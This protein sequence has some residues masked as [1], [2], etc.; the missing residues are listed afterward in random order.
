MTSIGEVVARLLQAIE[1]IDRAAIN[2]DGARNESELSHKSFVE[3]GQG[4][5]DPRMR[6]A[7]TESRTAS[8]KAGK[9]ARLL[10]EAAGHF[11]AYINIIAP[12]SA[13]SP[14]DAMPSG[15]EL[16]AEAAARER[17]ASRYHRKASEA[18]AN[19]AEKIQKAEQATTELVSIIKDRIR[20]GDAQANVATPAKPPLTPPQAPRSGHP[21]AD[22]VLAA[23]AV[24][25]AVRAVA[26]SIKKR[27]E[28]KRVDDDQATD[29]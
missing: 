16:V 28:R 6:A 20:P 29:N 27:R 25:V 18:V 19:N 4:T 8:E 14:P 7:I 9:V 2:A 21:I 12:G 5:A 15:E 26:Q 24:G 10:S 11:T 22:T 13:T 1:A 3:A 17:R 23:A